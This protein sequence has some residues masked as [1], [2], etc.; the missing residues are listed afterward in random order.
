MV[1]ITFDGGITGFPMAD[2][3]L[4]YMSEVRRGQGNTTTDS[5]GKFAIGYV[6]DDWRVNSKLTINLGLMYQVATRPY[7]KTDRLGNLWVRKDSS[8]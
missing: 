8:R 5:I 2:A 4:G 7:D 3:L 1:V 6:S